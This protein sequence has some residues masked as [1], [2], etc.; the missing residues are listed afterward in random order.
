MNKM[1]YGKSVMALCLISLILM[2]FLVGCSGSGT[3]SEG[4]ASSA[5]VGAGAVAIPVQVYTTVPQ[6]IASYLR[7]GGDVVPSVSVDILTEL[8]GKVSA[9]HVDV[10]D[11]VVKDQVLL[12]VDPSRPGS[13]FNVSQ[14]KAIQGGTITSF[15]PVV[16]VTVT[17]TMSLGKISDTDHPEITFS[18]VERYVS[19]I[20]EGQKAQVS[21]AAYPDE[22]FSATVTKVAP[23]LDAAS[24]TLK[25]TC[26]LDLP[27]ERILTGMYAKIQVLTEQRE[28]RV[29]IPYGAVLT[30]GGKPH[31][32]IVDDSRSP[33]VAIRKDV[34]LGLRSDTVVEVSG[35]LQLGDTVVVKGQT[36]LSD[37]SPIT[38]SSTLEEIR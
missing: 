10:G 7:F 15:S 17:P 8:T 34:M 20:R 28:D 38:V 24:R 36:L 32:Y 6:S 14:V 19:Q 4:E 16:G 3:L 30:S 37:G 29:V 31:V 5:T 23:T 33:A 25:A 21:F 26:S 27:D 11:R 2:G 13:T 9:V 1:Q 18:V 22:V 12:D 35:G